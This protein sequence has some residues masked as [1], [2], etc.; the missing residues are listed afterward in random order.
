MKVKNYYFII[1]SLIFVYQCENEPI[2][3]ELDDQGYQFDS[4]NTKTTNFQTIQQPNILGKS[5]KI[6]LG[7]LETKKSYGLVQIKGNVF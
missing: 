1:I 3:V 4:F 7:P 6:Y 5:A 2:N